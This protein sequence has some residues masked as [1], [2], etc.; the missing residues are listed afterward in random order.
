V[1]STEGAWEAG[2]DGALPGIVMPADPQPGHAYRQ[3]FYRGEAED[4]AEVLRLDDTATVP[5][6]S[7]DGVVTIREWTPLEPDVVEEKRYAPGVGMVAE[8]KVTGG[9]ERAEL[10]E[11]TPGGG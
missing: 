5:V 3:E 9:G 4:L 10:I 11:F 1:V 7:Y 2:V 6:G 8:E